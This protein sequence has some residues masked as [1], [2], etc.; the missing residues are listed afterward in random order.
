[1][2]VYCYNYKQVHSYSHYHC[3]YRGTRYTINETGCTLQQ[4]NLISLNNNYY[5]MGFA[6]FSMSTKNLQTGNA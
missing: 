5:Y 6:Y 4:A 1:M 2:L 3:V